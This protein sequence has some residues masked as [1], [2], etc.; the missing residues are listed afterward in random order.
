MGDTGIKHTS[1]AKAVKF[2]KKK[3][4]EVTQGGRHAIAINSDDVLI[5]IPRHNKISIGVTKKIYTQF[6]DVCGFDA[7]EVYKALK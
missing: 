5:S 3:D 7:A 1:Y 2:A 6:V 4:F